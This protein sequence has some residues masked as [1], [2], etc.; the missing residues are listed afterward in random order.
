L[1]PRTDSPRHFV[2]QGAAHCRSGRVVGG[3][4]DLDFA[5]LGL[6]YFDANAALFVKFL[7]S[8]P[9]FLNGMGMTELLRL[10]FFLMTFGEGLSVSFPSSQIISVETP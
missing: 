7:C 8:L 5:V 4:D 6:V 10:W 1:R 2:L 9:R 3:L